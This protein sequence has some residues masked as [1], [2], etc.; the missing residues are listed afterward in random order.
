MFNLRK[1][2]DKLRKISIQLKKTS[3]ENR[4]T[5]EKINILEK[6]I[7]QL[8]HKISDLKIEKFPVIEL[9]NYIISTTENYK[10]YLIYVDAQTKI[11]RIWN[12]GKRMKE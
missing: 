4:V 12:C 7:N 10:K 9:G 2:L 11:L 1:S 8:E 5:Q 6:M 3:D